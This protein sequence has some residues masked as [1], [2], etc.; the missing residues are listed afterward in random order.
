[1]EREEEYLGAGM[2]IVFLI[3]L[4]MALIIANVLVSAA[5]PRK[6]AEKGFA[7]TATEYIDDPEVL[8]AMQN[9][10]ESTAML[11]GS[12]HA[13]NAKLNLLNERV[14][15]LEKVVSGMIN[16]KITTSEKKEIETDS[17]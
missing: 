8:Q 5:R 1:V 13:V 9:V 11:H 2:I 17:E 15:T 4:I 12:I 3:V 16:E 6:S 7:N 14:T 10:H